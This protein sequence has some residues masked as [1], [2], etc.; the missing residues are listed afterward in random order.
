MKVAVTGGTGFVGS[1]T[2][3]A[4]SA[5][6]HEV[7]LLVRNPDRLGPAF[8]PLGLA[9]SIEVLVGEVTDAEDIGRLLDGCDAVIHAAS[10]Y[11]LDSRDTA[12]IR[13]INIEG[14]RLVIEAGRRIGLDPI[15]HVSSISA[16]LPASS[17]LSPDSPVARATGPYGRSKADSERL[18][19]QHQ[20]EG[21]PVVTVMPSSVWGP[22]DPHFGESCRVVA[23]FLRGYT[24]VLPA[25]GSMTIVD[26]R[27]VAAVLV[28]A[29]ERGLGPRRYLVAPHRISL[30]DLCASMNRLTGRRIRYVRLPNPVITAA[31]ALMDSLQRLLPF[32]LPISGEGARLTLAW[33]SADSS[34]A[35]HEFGIDWTPLD[36]TITDTITS[37]VKHGQ[38]ASPDA[39]ALGY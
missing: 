5:A 20:A 29:I 33:P 31:V 23:N 32:R 8:E 10:V 6:G 4:L 25:R 39:G 22:H 14:T 3:A 9:A 34:T 17:P 27:D 37:M 7:R 38:L 26:V 11:S 30:G 18:A 24:R 21:A 13:A 2:V 35:A 28:G 12:R 15:V 36:N 16:M 19:R 1:H